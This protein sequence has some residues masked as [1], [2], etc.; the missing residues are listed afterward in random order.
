[1]INKETIITMIITISS[2]GCDCEKIMEDISVSKSNEITIK[3]AD[4]INKE[5]FRLLKIINGIDKETNELEKDKLR[6]Q[7][8][9]YTQLTMD[10]T[11]SCPKENFISSD[12]NKIPKFIK[13]EI[14]TAVSETIKEEGNS[15]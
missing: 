6:K 7:I 2:S 11:L 1:M 4:I 12:E 3:I 10:I 9:D 13:D 14:L 5:K 15:I 8:G